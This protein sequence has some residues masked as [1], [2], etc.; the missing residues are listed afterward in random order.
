MVD[1]TAD[2]DG[3]GLLDYVSELDRVCQQVSEA[4]D[5]GFQFIILSDRAAGPK[6]HKK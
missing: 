3:T 2:A 4:V 5:E 6:R 1:I